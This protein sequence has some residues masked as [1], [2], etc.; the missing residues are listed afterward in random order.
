MQKGTGLKIGIFTF[1]CLWYSGSTGAGQPSDMFYDPAD[2]TGPC[3]RHTGGSS[4][5]SAVLCCSSFLPLLFMGGGEGEGEGSCPPHLHL[6]KCSI[7]RPCMKG[8]GLARFVCRSYPISQAEHMNSRA[9][10]GTVFLDCQSRAL[11]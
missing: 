2:I 11:G 8:P 3:P 4:C 10:N 9:N 7:F 1:T 6:R 5:C